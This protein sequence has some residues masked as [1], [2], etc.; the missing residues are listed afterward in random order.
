TIRPNLVENS[1]DFKQYL[2]SHSSST[3][4]SI[5]VN[6]TL[7][8]NLKRPVNVTLYSNPA[9]TSSIAVL[10]VV[11]G[12]INGFNLQAECQSTCS[13]VVS[14]EA[15]PITSESAKY[16]DFLVPGLI[17]FSVLTSPMFSMVNISS[18]YKKS[19]F[20][21]QLSQERR[22]RRSGRKPHHV[23][24]DVPLR[25]FLPSKPDARIPSERCPRTAII[26]CH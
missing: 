11:N 16:I 22:V 7:R 18:D 20:F 17:G 23:P 8:Y 3:G 21:K 25:N 2:L 1:V 9:D 6:F 19:K 12:V 24:H 26:L 4:I 10:A 15:S 5:P 14:L 13:P